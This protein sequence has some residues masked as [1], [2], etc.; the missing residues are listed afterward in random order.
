MDVFEDVR[1]AIEFDQMAIGSI[2]YTLV[3][4]RT[5]LLEGLAQRFMLWSE[6]EREF[7]TFDGNILNHYLDWNELNAEDLPEKKR[8]GCSCCQGISRKR[9]ATRSRHKTPHV[10]YMTWDF[11]YSDY[12]RPWR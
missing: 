8:P 6:R 12:L 4:T 2:D 5:S 3:D 9:S 11:P 7:P 1:Q 10:T